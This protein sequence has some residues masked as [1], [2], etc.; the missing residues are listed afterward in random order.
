MINNKKRFH[1]CKGLFWD[2]KL[3]LHGYPSYM[4]AFCPRCNCFLEKSREAYSIGEY[5]YQCQNSDCDFKITLRKSVEK[6]SGEVSQLIN[7]EQYKDAEVINLDNDLIRIQRE[8]RFDN[9]YWIDAKIS[10]NRRGELQ[11]MVLAGSKNNEDKVQ[12]FLDPT[13]ERLAF[14]Q[15]NDHPSQIFAKVVG[16]FK[17]SKAEIH[18]KK[19]KI[20]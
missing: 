2:Y 16:V 18:S 17:N 5:K 4:T 20:N 12:L 8:S 19:K 6:L 1:S 9:N 7:A 13:N 11:L 15:N 10:K 3:D 14:D